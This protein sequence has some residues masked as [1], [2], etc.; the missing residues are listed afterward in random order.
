VSE[1]EKAKAKT[2]EKVD[3]AGAKEKAEANE[4]VRM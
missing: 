2:S 1:K 3:E 4:D